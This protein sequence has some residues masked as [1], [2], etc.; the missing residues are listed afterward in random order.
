MGTDSQKYIFQC[1]N[2]GHLHKI[3]IRYDIESDL[4]TQAKCPRCRGETQ[5][6]WC[7]EHPEDVGWYGNVNVDPRYYQYNKTQQ[8]D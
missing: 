2:C 1:Q 4:Y 5:H 3:K 6:L 8:N 7:G